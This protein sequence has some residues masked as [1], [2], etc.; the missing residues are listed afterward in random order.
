MQGGGWHFSRAHLGTCARP[1]VFG[2][3]PFRVVWSPQN[4][5]LTRQQVCWAQRV[6]PNGWYQ[7]GNRTGKTFREAKKGTGRDRPAAI[8]NVLVKLYVVATTL[9]GPGLGPTQ[10]TTSLSHNPA[11][12]A[13]P[14][15]KSRVNWFAVSCHRASAPH[16]TNICNRRNR[17]CLEQVGKEALFDNSGAHTMGRGGA[18]S[19]DPRAHSV[20]RALV[21]LPRPTALLK[22]V[23][24][25]I[26]NVCLSSCSP[27]SNLACC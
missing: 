23:C 24:V 12:C 7:V 27:M 9:R 10:D 14:F 20:T 19:E 21:A 1:I 25:L 8:L 4:F 11:E 15:L 13:E 26:T 6:L 17:W 22:P 5:W 16:S 3:W 2:R 18:T